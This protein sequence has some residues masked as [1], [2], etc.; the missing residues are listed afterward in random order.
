MRDL[1]VDLKVVDL[2]PELWHSF[3]LHLTEEDRLCSSPLTSRF[4]MLCTSVMHL[5]KWPVKR[6]PPCVY[7]GDD[8]NGEAAYELK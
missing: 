1:M 3:V 4:Y 5:I 8:L 6:I 2:K 7:S